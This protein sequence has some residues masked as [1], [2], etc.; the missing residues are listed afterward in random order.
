MK[1]RWRFLLVLFLFISVSV[2]DGFDDDDDDDDNDGVVEEV[3][4]ENV[5]KEKVCNFLLLKKKK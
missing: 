5:V 4:D 2:S 3:P 1:P